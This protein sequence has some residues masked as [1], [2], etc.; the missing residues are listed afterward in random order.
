MR[1]ETVVNA[2]TVVR[3]LNIH[4]RHGCNGTGDGLGSLRDEI[5]FKPRGNGNESRGTP[6]TV[7]A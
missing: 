4:A 7:L 3:L 1:N 6:T 5:D 2:S